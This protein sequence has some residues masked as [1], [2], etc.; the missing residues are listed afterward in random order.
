MM[1]R[2]HLHL[3]MF[4]I[5]LAVS[6][7]QAQTQTRIN[8]E[9]GAHANYLDASDYYGINTPSYSNE[10]SK[11]QAGIELGALISLD[12]LEDDFGLGVE[13]A[14]FGDY[15]ADAL[16]FC[17]STLCT[18]N[19]ELEHSA[20]MFNGYSPSISLGDFAL[21]GFVGMS[22]VFAEGVIKDHDWKNNSIGFQLGGKLY[23]PLNDAVT[24]YMGFRF[25]SFEIESADDD[26]DIIDLSLMFGA[27]F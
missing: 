7:A 13:F 11:V 27:Q 17:N 22:R 15:K 21:R 5:M 16:S 10:S 9:V 23:W 12:L 2:I 4:I 24:P 3:P 18:R 14:S 25:H 8:W 1:K 26:V 6:Q 20:L 19:T